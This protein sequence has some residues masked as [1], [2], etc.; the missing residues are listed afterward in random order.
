MARNT[1][2]DIWM[3]LAPD[4]TSL[5]TPPKNKIQKQC[6]PPSSHRLPFD[7]LVPHEPP[8]S[9]TYH[10]ACCVHETVPEN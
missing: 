2:N 4:T 10:G 1:N 3:R 7:L 9:P 5:T 6:A 8:V